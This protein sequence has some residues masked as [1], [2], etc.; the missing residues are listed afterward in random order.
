MLTENP[1]NSFRMYG[2]VV[3]DPHVYRNRDGSMKV[4]MTIAVEDETPRPDG[5]RSFQHIPVETFYG[6]RYVE[7][8]GDAVKDA[9]RKGD[10]VSATGRLEMHS[11]TGADGNPQNRLTLFCL[12]TPSVVAPGAEPAAEP[13]LLHR[14]AGIAGQEAAAH[15]SPDPPA[16][17]PVQVQGPPDTEP[18][19]LNRMHPVRQPVTAPDPVQVQG[20]PDTEP[21]LLYRLPAARSPIA[22]PDPA[23]VRGPANT[24]PF[25]LNRFPAPTFQTVAPLPAQHA[26]EVAQVQGPPDTEPFAL[27]R[28]PEVQTLQPAAPAMAARPVTVV[29]R[30][31][32]EYMP[33]LPGPATT[34]PFVLN[35]APIQAPAKVPT[36]APDEPAGETTI[37]GKLLGSDPAEPVIPT[38]DMD[39]LPFTFGPDQAKTVP[40]N[41]ATKPSDVPAQ[42]GYVSGASMPVGAGSSVRV[43]SGKPGEWEVKSHYRTLKSGR[44][45]LVQGHVAHR[46]SVKEKI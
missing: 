33:Q 9:V 38:D 43:P 7:S 15:G 36:A 42:L 10:T 32:T 37:R 27:H 12:D 18:F 34:L 14:N 40:T 11:W 6:R 44:R 39:D 30:P 3:R 17:D 2:T 16:P 21:F 4:A 35:A 31:V 5:G 24:E 46:V 22:T 23:Q 19:V 45:I 1:D 25:V 29:T 8:Y 26:P 28:L 13:Y 20:A 41:P